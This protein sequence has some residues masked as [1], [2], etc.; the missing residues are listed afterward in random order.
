MRGKCY[1]ALRLALFPAAFLGAAAVGAED[2][3]TAPEKQRP[4]TV[5]VLD[6]SIG[7]D[8]KIGDVSKI[9][10]ARAELGQAVGDHGD[11]LA[12]GLVAFGHR[13]KANC[14][15]SEILAKP[16]ELTAETHGKLLDFKPQGQAPVAAALSDA[17]KVMPSPDGRLD[18][19]L[20]AAG[21]DSCGADICDTAAAL[22][23][24]SPALRIHAIGLDAGV[25]DLKPIACA[26]AAT[27]GEFI[28]ATDADTFKQGLATVLEAIVN[29]PPMVRSV[30]TVTIPPAEGETEASAESTSDAPD[31][32]QAGPGESAVQK[33]ASATPPPPGHP[34]ETE[35]HKSGASP[36]APSMTLALRAPAPKPAPPQ[37]PVPVTF[38]ALV[39]EVGPK[40]QTGLTWR[41]YASQ[42]ATDGRHKL[43]STHREA[44]PT[45]ALLPGEYLVNAAYGLSNLTKKVKV[46]G[47]RSV[48]ETFILNTGGLKL[49]AMLADGGAVP[50]QGIRFDILSDEEDQ[51]GKR[52]TILADAKPGVVVRLN[53]G[54]YHVVSVYGD[55][56]AAV[57][58]DVTVEPGKITEATVKHNGAK[59]T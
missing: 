59:I 19:I 46:E 32:A 42:A 40:L 27:N 9:D 55:A 3:P 12:F 51:F 6:G 14:A 21:G 2:A 38:K 4:A 20:I 44:T 26:T 56:N 43:I 24:Q 16:G 7:M 13:K 53:A 39:T 15:D 50:E 41:V 18:I 8:A 47:G 34:G 5:I 28:A 52:V 33:S 31:A 1:A 37:R 11:R 30:A 49:A 23:E 45:A 25:E 57:K 48:E 58:A 36:E 35:V 54:A 29:P 10:A 17:V 22:K